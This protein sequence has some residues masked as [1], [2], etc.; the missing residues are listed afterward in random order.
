MDN[1]AEFKKYLQSLSI[2]ER[3]FVDFFDFYNNDF[4][5]YGNEVYE[6]IRS[7]LTHLK[8]F[9]ENSWW[10]NR[11][12]FLWKYFAK[13][14]QIVDLGFSVPYLPLHLNQENM[15]KE[16]PQ[17]LYV[18]GND[19]SKKLAQNILTGLDIKA[20]FVIGDLEDTTTWNSIK[21]NLM[22]E[23]VLFTSFET[24]E[25]LNDPEKFWKY[26]KN[27]MGSDMILSLPIGPKI[28]SHQSFFVNK[29]QVHSYIS[30]YLEIKEEK[31]FSGKDYGS[32][33]SIYTCFGVIK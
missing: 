28:P 13:Y 3:A 33:Y 5:E 21:E 1:I 16:I 15:L 29:E 11:F 17:L 8:Y 24:I 4:N 7:R 22:G 25:H 31:V 26:L 19:T 18:D 9:L 10:N 2:D 6:D 30:Q 12:H 23:K 14:S 32:D 20:Q 27:H